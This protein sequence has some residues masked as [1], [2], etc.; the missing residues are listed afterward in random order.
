MVIIRKAEISEIWFLEEMLYE[1]LYVTI[2]EPALPRSIIFE[3][4]IY[5]YIK[6]WG[7][8]YDCACVALNNDELIGVIWGRLFS[9]PEIGYG[10]FNDETPEIG[11]AVK[12]EFRS[13]GIGTRLIEAISQEY[14]KMNIEA[15]SLSVDKRNKALNLYVRTGFEIVAENGTTWTMRKI[16]L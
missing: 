10:Y 2:G 5:K 15:I 1:S 8:P 16:L 3:P 14:L 4:E 11:I 13:R 9:S 12:S 6:N 7:R